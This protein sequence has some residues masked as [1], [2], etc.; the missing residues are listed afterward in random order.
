MQHSIPVSHLNVEFYGAHK[1]KKANSFSV[2]VEF[3]IYCILC[4]PNM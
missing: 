2:K 4:P 3:F 1:Q